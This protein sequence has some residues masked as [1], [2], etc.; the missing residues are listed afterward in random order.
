MKDN[1][2]QEVYAKAIHDRLLA[3][4]VRR[5]DD[6]DNNPAV[7]D[8]RFGA[9]VLAKEMRLNWETVRNFIDRRGVAP[10]NSTLALIAKWCDDQDRHKHYGRPRVEVTINGTVYEGQLRPKRGQ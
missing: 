10:T 1:G 3:L 9:S 2:K 5:Q 7:K 6:L 4:M 8:K